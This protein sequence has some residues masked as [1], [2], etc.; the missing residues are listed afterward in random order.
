[1]AKKTLV[2]RSARDQVPSLK[3]ANEI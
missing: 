3:L 2:V 1:V